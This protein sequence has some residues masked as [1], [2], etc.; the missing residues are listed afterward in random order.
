MKRNIRTLSGILVVAI[1][2]SV[3]AGSGL[4]LAQG[5]NSSPL[6]DGDEDT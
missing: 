6:D 1:A 3:V 5:A 2:L 4:A